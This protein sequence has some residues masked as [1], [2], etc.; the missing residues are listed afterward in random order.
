M[1]DRRCFSTR[2]SSQSAHFP[3]Q[4]LDDF[5]LCQQHCRKTRNVHAPGVDQATKCQC[6]GATSLACACSKSSSSLSGRPQTASKHGD[7]AR[8]VISK[9][10]LVQHANSSEGGRPDKEAQV[11]AE[12]Q[13]VYLLCDDLLRAVHWPASVASPPHLHKLFCFQTTKVAIQ[14]D[15]RG[16]GS[17]ASHSFTPARGDLCAR[18]GFSRGLC[19]IKVLWMVRQSSGISASVRMRNI[20]RPLVSG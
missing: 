3:L 17:L 9:T 18:Y 10:R 11:K 19:R 7:A 20:E 14:T 2:R 1:V 15:M 5:S 6:L 12:F 13:V 4:E 16:T 8:R